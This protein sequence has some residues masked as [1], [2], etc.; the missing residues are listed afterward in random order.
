[1]FKNSFQNLFITKSSKM[2]QCATVVPDKIKQLESLLCIHDTPVPHTDS[3]QSVSEG[4]GRKGD[5]LPLYTSDAG[6]CMRSCSCLVTTTA[7]LVITDAFLPQLRVLLS[8][9]LAPCYMLRAM[10]SS[11]LASCYMLCAMLSQLRAPPRCDS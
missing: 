4:R 3:R 10:F 6:T 5:K 11:M 1:M 2:K 9:M 8:Q 7:R